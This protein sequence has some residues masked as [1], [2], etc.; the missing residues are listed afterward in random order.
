MLS[1][2]R[3]KVVT[4]EFLAL[5]A[6]QGSGSTTGGSE[7]PAGGSTTLFSPST[8]PPFGGGGSAAYYA[9]PVPFRLKRR[10]YVLNYHYLGT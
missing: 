9:I 6:L 10:I 2:Y 7:V 8:H 4:N 1:S 3:D 5:S